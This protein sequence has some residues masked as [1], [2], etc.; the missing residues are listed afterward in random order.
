MSTWRVLLDMAMG[1]GW[2]LLGAAIIG[3]LALIQR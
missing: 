3:V 1:A 2:L